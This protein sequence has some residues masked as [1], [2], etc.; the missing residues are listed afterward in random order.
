MDIVACHRLGETGRVIVKLLNR[1][2]AQNVLEEKHK[3]RSV[4]LYDDS[5]NTNNKRKIFINQSLRVYY[6]K[7]YGMAKDLNKKGLIDSFWIVNGTIK[8]R[9]S[10]RSKPISV[11]YESDLQF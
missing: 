8:I 2:D 3:L 9:E 7:L 1:K 5:T 10:S 11:T 4:N 6:R